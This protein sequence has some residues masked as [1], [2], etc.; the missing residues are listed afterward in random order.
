M[1]ASPATSAARKASAL[2]AAVTECLALTNALNA[3][4]IHRLLSSSWERLSWGALACMA[5]AVELKFVTF[6]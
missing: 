2:K 5:L 4:T 1:C 3:K 6:L